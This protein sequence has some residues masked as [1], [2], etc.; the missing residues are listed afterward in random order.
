MSF[1]RTKS[2]Q[3]NRAAFLGVDYICYVEGGGGHSERSDDI[4]FWKNL[5][6]TLRPD[7]KIHFIAK[8]GKAELEKRASDIIEKN[9][10]YSIVAMDSDFD[11]LLDGKISDRRILYTYGYSWENDVF[12]KP[13]LG[14]IYTHVARAPSVPDDEID[15]LNQ[16][17][18]R[19]SD[20]MLWPVRA[21]YYALAAKSSV[22]PRSSPG[23]LFERSV[24]SGLPVVRYEEVIKICAQENRRTKPRTLPTL[25]KLTDATRF[26]P[27]K[28]YSHLMILLVS[29]VL[30][31][32]FAQKRMTPLHCKDIALLLLPELLKNNKDDAMV[33]FYSAQL[34]T[35]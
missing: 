35:V 4:I 11:H 3:E 9:I 12:S 31:M 6:G 25:P 8:G 16:C 21:D 34:S 27:G 19:L 17:Y 7:L 1:E 5:L 2:G 30:K 32:N 10:S 33:S 18:D 28:V 20:R 15:F 13:M 22:L 14:R 26:C 23:R 29:A 24:S